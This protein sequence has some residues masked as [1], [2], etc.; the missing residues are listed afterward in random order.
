MDIVRHSIKALR[1]RP[2]AFG[3]CRIVVAGN[4]GNPSG[5]SELRQLVGR[6]AKLLGERD[7]GEITRYDHVVGPLLFEVCKQSRQHLGAVQTAAPKRPRKPAKE[8]LAE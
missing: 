1:S 7:V 3:Q 4:D 5:V 8:T 6:L 2:N